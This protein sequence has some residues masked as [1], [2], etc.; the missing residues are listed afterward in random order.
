[1]GNLWSRRKQCQAVASAAVLSVMLAVVAGCGGG[2]SGGG[3]PAPVTPA[4]GTVSGRVVSLANNSP[5]SGATVKTDTGT[6]TTAADGKFSV[7]ALAGDRILLHVEANE[8]AE[9]FPVARVISGQ[10][11]N[12]GVKLVPT[13]V[14]T[15]VSVAAGGTV[16]VPNSTARVTMPAN[17]L[18]PQA[19]GASAG[20]VSVSVTPINPATDPNLMPGGFN[21]I[22]AGGSSTQPIESFGAMLVDIRDSAGARYTLAGGNSSTI[23]IPLGTNSTN[24]PATVPLWFFDDTAGVWKEEGTATLQGTAPNRYYEGTVAHFSYWN[25]DIVTETIVVTGCVKDANNQP[26]ANAFVRTEGTDYTGEAVDFTAADGTF[27]VAMRKSSR[28]KLGLYEF[29]LQTFN[30]TP[31]SNTVNVGPSATD[32]ALPNC[33]VKQPGPLAIT[34]AAL[35]GGNVGVAYN[36]TL[37][38]SGGV[39]GYVWSLN[40]GSNPLPGGLSLNPSGVIS[41]TPTAAGTTAI[42]IKVTDSAGEAAT[43][44]FTLTIAAPNVQPLLL[45]TT[46]LPAGTVS[47]A[48]NVTLAATGGT[49]N[50]TWS[51]SSGTLPAGLSLNAASGVISGTPT[52]AGVFPLTMRVQDSGTPQQSAEQQLS[53]TILSAGGGGGGGS[54]GGTGGGQLT[55]S[56]APASVGGTFVANPQFIAQ[57]QTLGVASVAWHEVRDNYAE[58][59]VISFDAVTGRVISLLFG[60]GFE[61]SPGKSWH[62][63]GTPGTPVCNGITVDRSAGTVTFS[64]TVL[65]APLANTDPPV[66]LNGTLTFEPF[67]ILNPPSLPVGTVNRAYSEA[68]RGFGGTGEMSWSVIAGALPAGLALNQSTGVISGTPTAEGTSNFTIQVRDSGNPPQTHQ[69]QFSLKINPAGG[70]GGGDTLTITGAI[71]RVGGVFTPDPQRT[72]GVVHQGVGA[73]EVAWEEPQPSATDAETLIIGIDL[74]TNRVFYAVFLSAALGGATPDA[75]TWEC[76]DDDP[77]F[78]PCSGINVNRSA[79]TAS[80]TNVLLDPANSADSRITVNGTLTFSPF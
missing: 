55:I 9:A 16:S 26:V 30:F 76:R 73:A 32:I 60:A 72:R 80:V 49:G 36:Q 19:G 75:R 8:F 58:G 74:N 52:A 34:T 43:K 77:R 23:R 46:A 37:A 44:T 63:F 68:M 40:T 78:R 3:T 59:V 70:A 31:I 13:G 10:T 47:T 67:L 39:P 21:G 41:G 28:A 12:L 56:N 53:I 79:G 25:A 45:M 54:G 69:K 27:Q 51:V 38:A 66:T 14:T 7:S 35:S 42:T 57:D 64:N 20:T 29:D 71:P 33:L 22:S 2:D 62:C 4:T 5:V 65:N 24:P 61:G 17:G 15:T 18:V 6:T 50:K 48:Y 11:T 1:M